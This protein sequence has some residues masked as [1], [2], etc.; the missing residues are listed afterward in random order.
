MT[1]CGRQWAS[2][3]GDTA[4]LAKMIAWLKDTGLSLAKALGV[5]LTAFTAFKVVTGIINGIKIAWTAF[6]ASVWANPLT[7]CASGLCPCCVDAVQ[8]LGWCLR[9]AKALGEDADFF[10]WGRGIADGF[11]AL[12]DDIASAWDA[13][14][15]F[16]ADLIGQGANALSGFVSL[17][18]DKAAEAGD[19]ISTGFSGTWQG[20]QDGAEALGSDIG[21]ALTPRLSAVGVAGHEG[22]SRCGR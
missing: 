19:A 4:A 9:R 22:R 1:L 10:S 11:S 2:S 15:D 3:K 21:S 14:T 17:C 18:S 12:S 6:T 7:P 20:I 16:F 5:L 8:K 13:V